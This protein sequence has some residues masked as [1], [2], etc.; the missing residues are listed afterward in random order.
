MIRQA[1]ILKPE[2][3]L[4]LAHSSTQTIQHA[5]MPIIQHGSTSKIKIC[6]AQH[7]DIEGNQDSF[8]D[9]RYTDL[10]HDKDL[11]KRQ[12]EGHVSHGSP[13]LKAL[14]ELITKV[15]HQNEG[16]SRFGHVQGNNSR[17]TTVVSLPL[18]PPKLSL[19]IP[20][21]LT[22]RPP[23]HKKIVHRALNPRIIS[24]NT[25]PQSQPISSSSSLP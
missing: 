22:S 14:Q 6:S 17:N 24:P 8:P 9:R 25:L 16:I 4:T 19:N 11:R 23:S 13:H 5:S 15:D 12:I 2:K 21:S 7:L 3:V 1:K 10:M 20:T 18:T